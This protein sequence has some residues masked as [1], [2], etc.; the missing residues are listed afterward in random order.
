MTCR[1]P[2]A[3]GPGQIWDQPG[4]RQPEGHRRAHRCPC[5]GPASVPWGVEGLDRR[6]S[7]PDRSPNAGPQRPPQ[8][9]LL[10]PVGGAVRQRRQSQ[11][12]PIQPAEQ[13]VGRFGGGW[14]QGSSPTGQS[15]KAARVVGSSHTQGLAAPKEDHRMRVG[16]GGWRPDRWG[17]IAALPSGVSSDVR[18][19]GE[20]LVEVRAASGSTLGTTSK[21]RLRIF[22]ASTLDLWSEE[23][24]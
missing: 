12:H 4:L 18:F 20:I 17:G 9:G 6:G 16:P 14:R 24:P 3:A 11:S 8:A 19:W 2:E 21:E 23:P 5:C 10:R 7:N 22:Q 15:R 1:Q 13:A